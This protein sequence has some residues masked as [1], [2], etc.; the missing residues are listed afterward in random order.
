[1]GGVMMSLTSELTMLVKAA[2]MTTPTARSTTLPRMANFLNSEKMAMVRSRPTKLIGTPA[3]NKTADQPQE[4]EAGRD[5]GANPND[6]GQLVAPF[7]V[8]ADKAL[9]DLQ[10]PAEGRQG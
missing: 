7:R 5:T 8:A 1:M 10:R 9:H 4:D 6:V 2:P 3:A